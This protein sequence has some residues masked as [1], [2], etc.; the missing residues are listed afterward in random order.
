MGAGKDAEFLLEVQRDGLV[1]DVQVLGP[2]QTVVENSDIES[3]VSKMGRCLAVTTGLRLVC[4]P[5]A[6]IAL[7]KIAMLVLSVYE[8]KEELC[9]RTSKQLNS[10]ALAKAMATRKKMSHS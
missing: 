3:R 2:G 7:V 8:G 4:P 6:E 5:Y 1:V 10:S 9:E